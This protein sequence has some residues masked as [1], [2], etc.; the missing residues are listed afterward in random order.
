M[1]SKDRAPGAYEDPQ[2]SWERVES[3]GAETAGDLSIPSS[4]RTSRRSRDTGFRRHP[5]YLVSPPDD[6]LR[7]DPGENIT[8]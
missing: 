7:H 6:K 2:Q 5:G 1:V 8:G 4:C 3:A